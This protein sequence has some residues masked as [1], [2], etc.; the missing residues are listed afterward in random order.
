MVLNEENP[1]FL[2][3]F[4]GAFLVLLGNGDGTFTNLPGAGLSSQAL[5]RLPSRT[6]MEMEN[7]TLRW[8]VM[9]LA[10]SPFSL[11]M[12]TGPLLRRLYRL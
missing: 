4:V 6:S 2:A 3:G 9:S 5:H 11:A 10:R 8:R 7:P 12:A 1:P